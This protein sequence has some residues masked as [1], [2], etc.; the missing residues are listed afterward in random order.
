MK[1]WE[2][3]LHY[4]ALL[5]V[6]LS[7]AGELLL[8]ANVRFILDD[9]FFPFGVLFLAQTFF[10]HPKWRWFIFA[11]GAM[12]VW[13]M[14]SD[15]LANGTVR[16]AP[17]GMLLRWLKW[18]IMCIAI[19]ELGQLKIKRSQVENGVVISFLVLAG[20]NILMM[21]NPF[22]FG[23]WLSEMYTPKIEMLL[24]NYHEFGAFRLSGTMLNPNTNAILFG[25][26]L[27]FFLHMNARKYWQYIL[28]AFILVFLTQSRTVMLMSL[29]IFALFV[30]SANTRKVN[31][32]IIPA[33]ILS[34]IVGLFLFRSTNLMSIFNGS[35]FQ[36]NSWTQRM[37]HYEILFKGG[38]NNMLLGHGIVLDPIASVGFYFDSEYLSIGYQY[39]LIGLFIW[40]VIIGLLL[41]VSLK[42]NRESTF[43][44]AL[45]LF[46][47]GIAATNFT[48]LN[49]ECA[50]LMLALVGAWLFL[51][52]DDKFNDH[53]QEKAK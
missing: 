45:V 7:L 50:T 34:L 3:I 25:L 9:L 32:I 46:I 27:I 24:S 15:V 41:R 44:W 5:F 52:S 53:P 2:R 26:F 22:G 20:I 31:M 19:A 33:G 43:A 21:I 8:P 39:G 10:K 29:V 14:L 13:G 37:E 18:P 11:F 48:F 35:A 28:L 36:S 16:T 23:R 30:L 38:F 42:V 6:V 47:F 40:V 1:T 4:L 17:I 51:Q 12:T 49:V